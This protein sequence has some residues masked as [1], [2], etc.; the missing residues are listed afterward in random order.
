MEAIVIRS[1]DPD[2]E[3]VAVFRAAVRVYANWCR[4]HN[5]AVVTATTMRIDPGKRSYMLYAA[6]GP[7]ISG[8]IEL[9]Y[10]H[11]TASPDLIA[12]ETAKRTVQPVRATI[13]ACRNV[14]SGSLRVCGWHVDACGRSPKLTRT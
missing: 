12:E 10:R 13:P 4:E 11:W 8:A 3:A 2:P 14:A 1:D 5:L 9:C 6:D 7:L